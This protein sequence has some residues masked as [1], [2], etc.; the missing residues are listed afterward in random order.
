M[1]EAREY[2]QVMEV[3][4]LFK[5]Y[6]KQELWPSARGL[7]LRRDMGQGQW[8]LKGRKDLYRENLKRRVF[9]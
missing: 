8:K 4:S 7:E 6:N 2:L 9:G 1:I 3:C 5:C